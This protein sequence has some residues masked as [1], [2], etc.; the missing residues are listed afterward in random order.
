MLSELSGVL[1]TGGFILAASTFVAA[2]A[3]EKESTDEGDANV[4]LQSFNSA[5]KSLVS[6]NKKGDKLILAPSFGGSY[7]A[8]ESA[9]A[10]AGILLSAN[11]KDQHAVIDL[12]KLMK[13]SASFAAE[14]KIQAALVEEGLLLLPGEAFDC[15]QPGQFRITAP[16]LSA[17]EIASI[18]DKLYR[19]AAKFNVTLAKRPAAVVSSEDTPSHNSTEKGDEDEESVV[20]TVHE[21]SRKK[22]RS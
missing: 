18:V 17:S 11:A 16:D 7:G 13:G 5:Y 12:Q 15:P 1:L 2:N 8:L 19:V 4:A 10:K 20:S 9:L 21:S 6:N 14:R 22:R 3:P